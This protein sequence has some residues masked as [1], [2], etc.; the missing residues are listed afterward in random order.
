MCKAHRKVLLAATTLE[1]EIKKL[2]R[3]R[4]RS[5]PEQRRKE[6]QRPEE[7][8]RK[9]QCQVSLSSQPTAS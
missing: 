6:S 1:K 8:R 4:A 9:R 7:R 3:M 2:H 5:G